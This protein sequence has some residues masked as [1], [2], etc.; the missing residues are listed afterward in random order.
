MTPRVVYVTGWCRSGTTLLGNILNEVPGVAHV[1]EV[2][3]LWRNG[4]SDTGTNSRCGCGETVSECPVWS[5]V[6][7]DLGGDDPE[8]AARHWQQRQERLLRTRHVVRRAGEARR[9]SA[10]AEVRGL[11]DDLVALYTAI[12]AR[13]GAGVVVDSS[14]YPAEAAAL[15]GRGDLDLRVLHVVRDPRAVAESWRK[16]KDYIPSMSAGRSTG[17]WDAFNVA[18]EVAGR[19]RPESYLRVRYE[20]LCRRPVDVVEQVLAFAGLE[21]PAPVHP[22][23]TVLLGTNHTV[24]GNPDRLRNGVTTIRPDVRWPATLPS[25]QRRTVEVLAAPLARRYGYSR[26]TTALATPTPERAS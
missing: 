26:H 2:R 10:G 18:S 15:A 9:G 13:T 4:V 12:G 16:P 20:D 24:T 23:S 11:L 17:Y 22:D 1:G 7:T 19:I 14:K 3:Y 8:G 6:L 25:R 21:A 5:R